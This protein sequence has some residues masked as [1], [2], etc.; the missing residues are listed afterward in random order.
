MSYSYSIPTTFTLIATGVIEF[1]VDLNM[2][3]VI[4]VTPNDTLVVICESTRRASSIVWRF[5]GET[6]QQL[7]SGNST[8][9]D[10][11]PGESSLDNAFSVNVSP[12]RAVLSITGATMAN[13]GVYE[14]TAEAD[15]GETDSANV[16][17]M[18]GE[19]AC[20]RTRQCDVS[21]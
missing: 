2:D 3:G 15:S 20:C 8:G 11:I 16:T 5:E 19:C 1:K 17:V 21:G 4:R 14:C 7:P 12:T 10:I 18:F 13:V 9:D 6:L